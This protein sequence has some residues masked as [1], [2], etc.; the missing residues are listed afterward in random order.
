MGVGALFGLAAM[1]GAAKGEERVF[2][3][4]VANQSQAVEALQDNGGQVLITY[5]NF[6]FIAGLIP[7]NERPGLERDNRV[8]EVEDDT[9]IVAVQNGPGG[10]CKNQPTQ[11]PSWGHG[12]IGADSATTTGSGVDVAILD[13]GIDTNHCDHTLSGGHNCTRGPPRNYKDK[14]GHGTHCAGIA[15]ADDNG[16]GVA[17]VA[18]DTNLYAVKVLDDD[19]TGYWSWAVCGVDWCM[20]ANIEIMSMS[21]GANNASG[22]ILSAIDDAYAA[23]HLVVAAA[24]ND[25]HSD[26]CDDNSTVIQ[27]ARYEDTIAVS[28]LNQNDT[29]ADYSSVG[30]EVDLIAP[31]S[32]IRSTYENNSYETLSGTSMACPHVSGAAAAVWEARGVTGPDVEARNEVETVLANNTE[33]LFCD[34]ADGDGLVR[35]DWAV[36]AA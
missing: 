21:F 29:L 12:R 2:V 5:D 4:P 9:Q 30:P 15:S 25:G 36:E 11:E 17:G 24:G 18:P 22:G 10:R 3:Y 35:V 31:G 1:P 20:S 7:G 26:E 16:I 32:S 23:G 33:D 27:P 19:G 8:A 14:N 13:T 34:T 6:D 28:A